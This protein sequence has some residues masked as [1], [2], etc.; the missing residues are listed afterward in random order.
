MKTFYSPYQTIGF[1]LRPFQLRLLMIFLI[2][3]CI[4]A[5]SQEDYRVFT[6]SMSTPSTPSE[7]PRLTAPNRSSSL[8]S[9]CTDPDS[10]KYVNVNV[11]FVLKSDGTGN[12]DETSDGL[13]GSVSG[14][15]AAYD[16]IRTANELFANN[17]QVYQPIGNS[18]PALSTRIQYLLRGVYF[19]RNTTVYNYDYTDLWINGYF[20]NL[21]INPNSEINIFIAG[22]PIGASGV[23]RTI[24]TFNASPQVPVTLIGDQMWSSFNNGFTKNVFYQAS[25]ISLKLFYY[26]QIVTHELG[27]LLNLLHPFGCTSNPDFCSDTYTFCASS[28]PSNYEPFPPD[29]NPYNGLSCPTTQCTNT[30]MESSLNHFAVTPCQI[31]RMHDELESTTGMNYYD[32]DCL[33]P[34]PSFSIAEGDYTI[35]QNTLYLDCENPGTYVPV[36]INAAATQHENCYEVTVEDLTTNVS[37]TKIYYGTASSL[38][39]QY[40]FPNMEVDHVYSVRLKAINTCAEDSTE[41]IV[42][43]EY[44]FGCGEW[45]LKASPNPANETLTIEYNLAVEKETD[46]EISIVEFNNPANLKSLKSKGKQDKGKHSLQ[47]NTNALKS[48][49]YLIVLK[50][51]EKTLNYKVQIIH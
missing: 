21:A 9:A 1:L 35:Y 26:G 48:G 2:G 15:Q 38:N 31:D 27:H 43:I 39:L 47:I 44:E 8:R 5:Y 3:N 12:Y 7:S 11:H 34:I 33:E 24:G 45:F 25:P 41:V 4:N 51:L 46:T 36:F 28:N 23:A 42:S 10:T 37:Y 13:G 18:T 6:C 16:L 32:C 14:Y 50:T 40:V 19:L 29:T 20:D 30:F 17:P 22:E 49:T